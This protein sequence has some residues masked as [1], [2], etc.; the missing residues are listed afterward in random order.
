MKKFL[1][2]F[3]ILSCFFISCTRDSVLNYKESVVICKFSDIYFKRYWVT[4]RTKNT[5][6]TYYFKDVCVPKYEFDEVEI[7]DTIK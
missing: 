4:I 5:D 6:G 3:S 2:I 1:I 7:G